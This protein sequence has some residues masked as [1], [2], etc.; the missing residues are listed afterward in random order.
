M[1]VFHFRQ[2][3]LCLDAT[4]LLSEAP[5][6]FETD[7]TCHQHNKDNTK[8]IDDGQ[9]DGQGVQIPVMLV[10][11]H[12][13]KIH[14]NSKHSY[15]VANLVPKVHHRKVRRDEI[16]ERGEVKALEQNSALNERET[17][18][19]EQHRHS[20][21]NLFPIAPVF[22]AIDHEQGEQDT[23]EQGKL[24][25]GY[26]RRSWHNGNDEYTYIQGGR[27]PIECLGH[28]PP[29]PVTGLTCDQ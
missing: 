5:G 6:L 4:G 28:E 8:A 10:P 22:Q 11:P 12:G 19:E 16:E 3:F 23:G 13:P 26:S 20:Q 9:K 24:P 14:C 27:E 29:E 1:S 21:R 2:Q 18:Y 25:Q 7:N 15:R 17:Q